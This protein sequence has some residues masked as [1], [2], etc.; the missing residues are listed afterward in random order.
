MNDYKRLE[1][2]VEYCG[3]VHATTDGHFY[4]QWFPDPDENGVW[5]E[6]ETDFYSTIREAIDAA[7]NGLG[8]EATLW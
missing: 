4:T 2:L 5:V 7:I 1:F 8:K 3:L 6:M